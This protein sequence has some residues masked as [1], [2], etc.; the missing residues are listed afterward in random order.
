MTN[1]SRKRDEDLRLAVLLRD[2]VVPL[3]QVHFQAYLKIPLTVEMLYADPARRGLTRVFSA[4]GY[5]AIKV[6]IRVKEHSTRHIAWNY[7]KLPIDIPN[8]M[9]GARNYLR[10]QYLLFVDYN[11]RENRLDGY[12]L[13]RPEQLLATMEL[14]EAR[15]NANRVNFPFKKLGIRTTGYRLSGDGP[16]GMIEGQSIPPMAIALAREMELPA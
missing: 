10:D 8:T 3:I 14:S 12:A 6:N 4:E 16:G 9:T 7:I 1:E 11:E 2:K 13:V 15:S 5:R